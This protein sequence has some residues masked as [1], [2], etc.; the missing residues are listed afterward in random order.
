MTSDKINADILIKLDNKSITPN[1]QCAS[2]LKDC[3]IMVKLILKITN[4]YAKM[5]KVKKQIIIRTMIRIICLP[6][7]RMGVMMNKNMQ[8]IF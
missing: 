7:K 4:V 8:L 1:L 3:C 6:S 5:D 2:V